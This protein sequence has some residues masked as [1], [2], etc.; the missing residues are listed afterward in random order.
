MAGRE[1]P[2]GTAIGPVR[3]TW[4]GGVCAGLKRR[5]PFASMLLK[6]KITFAL[7]STSVHV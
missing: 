4:A 5:C 1:T 6:N 2:A 7:T 3:R